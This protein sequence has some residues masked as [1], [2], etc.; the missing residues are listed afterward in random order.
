MMEVKAYVR[1]QMVD[2]VIDA[3]NEQELVTGIAVVPL[4]EYGHADRSGKIRRIELTKLEM[5]VSDDLA[6][7]IVD[8]IVENARTGEGHPGDGKVFVSR[9]QRAVRI[10]DG[11][12]GE[13]ILRESAHHHPD[14]DHD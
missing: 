4:R 11:A 1:N 9:V 13:A 5:D 2:R 6:E 14:G 12:E 3:L 10:E 8:C 7:R